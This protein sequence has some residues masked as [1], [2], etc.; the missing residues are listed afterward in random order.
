MSLYY[1]E[2]LLAHEHHPAVPDSYKYLDNERQWLLIKSRSS[3]IAFL[4]Y[5]YH[6]HSTDNS[7]PNFQLLFGLFY[8]WS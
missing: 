7:S 3:K 8:K 6:I 5:E 1:D 4:R 2:N